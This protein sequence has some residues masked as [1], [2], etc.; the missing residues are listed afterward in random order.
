MVLVKSLPRRKPRRLTKHK[1]TS[2][3]LFVFGVLLIP[4]I[5]FLIFWGYVHLDSLFL[6]FRTDAR[7]NIFDNPEEVFSSLNVDCFIRAFSELSADNGGGI[8]LKA[9]FNTLI[10]FF[11]G[12]CISLPLAML[13]SYFFYKKIKGF[14]FFRVITYIPTIITSSAL[15]ALYVQTLD[16]GGPFHG[17][18]IAQGQSFSQI[19]LQS[20][21]WATFTMVFYSVAFGLGGSI[22]VIGGAMNSIDK[23]ILEAGELDGCNWVRE[24][25]SIIIP[26]IWPTISTIIL[27]SFVG[28]LGASG[29]LLAFYPYLKAQA[30]VSVDG[31]STLSFEMYRYI[32]GSELGKSGMSRDICYASCIGLLMSAVTIPIVLVVKRFTLDRE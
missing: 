25:F 17:L 19:Y 30:N 22:V 7:I 23:Q 20:N 12:L 10:Y 27:L 26:T 3:N 29:P 11:A 9:F 8:L 6:A 1:N 4:T 2:K 24:L 5:C 14:K 31:I 15:V 13:I 16:I 21:E 18:A 32:I 28:I